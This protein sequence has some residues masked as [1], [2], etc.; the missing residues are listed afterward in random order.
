[1]KKTKLLTSLALA[2]SA[3]GISAPVYADKNGA[4]KD[5]VPVYRLYNKNTGEH[6]YTPSAY[7]LI[8]LQ[9]AGWTPEGIGWYAPVTGEPVYR[10]YNPNAK[11]GD[12]YY[13][14]SKG[15][16]AYD[17][18]LGWKWDNNGKPAFYSDGKIDNFVAYNPNALSGAHNYTSDV[19]EQNS[20]IRLGWTYGAPA[21]KVL[22]AGTNAIDPDQIS[23]LNLTTIQGLWRNDKGQNLQVIGDQFIL[24]GKAEK[25]DP[26][27]TGMGVVGFAVSGDTFTQ[28]LFVL[29]PDAMIP[30]ARAD[31]VKSDLDEARIFIGKTPASGS[32]FYKVG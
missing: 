15:E 12:H 3:L 19:N 8:N 22:K 25:W 7:E 21:W 24:D 5:E 20:L 32:Y 26:V 11:G 31:A 1:M 14:T 27:Q 9:N 18:S 16:A 30:E 28:S 10:I 13:T 29:A 6:F 4:P 17:V 2:V 23:N